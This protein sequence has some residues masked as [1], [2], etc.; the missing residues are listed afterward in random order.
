[1]Q[2]GIW[3]LDAATGAGGSGAAAG[4]SAEKEVNSEKAERNSITML[5]YCQIMALG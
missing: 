5:K 4:A 2:E 3:D 1:M